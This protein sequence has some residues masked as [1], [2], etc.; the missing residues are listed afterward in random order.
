MGWYAPM[1]YFQCTSCGH[2][3]EYMQDTIFMATHDT[4]PTHC[5]KCGSSS[6]QSISEESYKSHGDFTK[7]SFK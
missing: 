2:K 6:V 7:D 5:N 4:S 1:Q 3:Y